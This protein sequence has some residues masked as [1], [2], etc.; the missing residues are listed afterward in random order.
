VD[1]VGVRQVLHY[2]LW[3]FCAGLVA[4][5]VASP[6]TLSLP[7]LVSGLSLYA[8]GLGMGN[9]ALYRLALFAS[10]D[11]KGLVSAMVGMISIAVMSATGSLLALL[12]AGASLESFALMVGIAGLG[13]LLALRLF[14][15]RP[16][17]QV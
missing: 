4:L 1:R 17:A 16:T 14:A 5:I 15:S 12:G 6:F 8:I 11:S 3:P 7:V 2:S 13:C 10:D 9:A